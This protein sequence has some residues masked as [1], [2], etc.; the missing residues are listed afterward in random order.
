MRSSQQSTVNQLLNDETLQSVLLLDLYEKM[1]YHHYQ[2]S[3]IPGSWLSHAQGAL[4]ILQSRPRSDFSNLATQQ[5]ATRT[6]IALTI[7]CGVTGVPIPE[8]L[9][10]L[11]HDLD[12]LVQ[13]AKW[14]FISLLMGLVNFRAEMRSGTLEISEILSRA[15]ELDNQFARAETKIPRDWWPRRVNARVLESF[16]CYYEIYPCHYT[17]QVFNAYR[18]MRL[19]LSGVIRKFSPGTSVN[20][21]IAEITQAI[22]AAVPQFMLPGVIPGNKLPLSP[23]QILECSGVLTPLY[24]AAQITT[25]TA[26]REWI[27]RS[28]LYMAD[29]GVKLAHSVAHI[30]SVQPEEDYWVIFKMVGS[31]ATTA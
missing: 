3:D 22:C 8:G 29:Q 11:Y 6:V 30:L 16:D 15:R 9:R 19:E 1:A 7:S 10:E 31:C 4:S 13:S 12:G 18:I 2:T 20:E 17:T 5:L 26:M 27:K 25:H 14:T 21:T 28:L 24:V 23:L